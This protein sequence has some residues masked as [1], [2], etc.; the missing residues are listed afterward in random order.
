MNAAA[1]VHPSEVHVLK[2]RL[3]GAFRALHQTE[4]AGQPLA[5]S[6]RGR[7]ARDLMH[8]WNAYVAR[9]ADWV[10]AP[11][12]LEH[13]RDLEARLAVLQGDARGASSSLHQTGTIAGLWTVG[14]LADL[15]DALSYTV[16]VVT[17]A[18][19]DCETQWRAADPAGAAAWKADFDQGIAQFGKAWDE[20]HAIVSLLPDWMPI[21]DA[22]PGLVK[23]A[24]T[25]AWD[26]VVATVHTFTGLDRTMRAAGVCAAPTYPN[27]PQPTRSDL[28]LKAF[29]LTGGAL[30]GIQKGAREVAK[31]VAS[32]VPWLAL[33]GVLALVLVATLKQ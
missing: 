32:P 11:Q 14:E 3:D 24:A 31:T 13:G 2:H 28:D 23:S 25:V 21:A 10:S 33:G 17:A 18:W 4:L 8:A 9:P 26:D 20:A 6:A 12:E 22:I 7:E 19:N 5:G 15:L 16:G 29:N 1:F 27:M 30:Q